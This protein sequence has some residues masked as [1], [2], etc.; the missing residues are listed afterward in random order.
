M[1]KIKSF[2]EIKKISQRLKKEGKIIVFTNG[3]FD[4]IHPGHIKLLKKGKSIGDILIV[5]LNNDKSIIKLKGKKRPIIDE[6]GRA[7][8]VSSFE[9]VDYLVL[10]GQET[11]EKLIK[12]ILPHYILKGGDYKEDQ[13]V[14]KEIVEKYG[15]KVI[16]FP[17]YKKY[18][19]TKIIKRMKN[20]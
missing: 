2:S 9:M 19:T 5:G 15:G 6:K 12:V 7:E 20:G 14:G 13:V 16:I 18:S 3:C 1:G 8:I 17:L 4:I 11:P 10:F